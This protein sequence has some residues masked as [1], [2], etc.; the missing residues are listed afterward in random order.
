M[1]RQSH[2]AFAARYLELKASLLASEGAKLTEFKR[3]RAAARPTEPQTTKRE[4]KSAASH[5]HH[6]QGSL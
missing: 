1:S 4:R 6:Q 2:T 3:A 5:Q